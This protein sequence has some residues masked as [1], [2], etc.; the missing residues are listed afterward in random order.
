MTSIFFLG[1]TL[2]WTGFLVAAATWLC[3]G[4]VPARFA[5]NIWRGAAFLAVVPWGLALGA[6]FM[7]TAMETPIP[8]MPILADAGAA[9]ASSP[10]VQTAVETASHPVISAWLWV[11]ILCGWGVRLGLSALSQLRLQ[12]IKAD[13]TPATDISATVWAQRLGLS[14]APTVSTMEHGSPFLAG[15][16]NRTI[17]L[18]ASVAKT[19]EANI[20]LAHECTH[21]A[22]G[23]LVSRP[24]ERLVADIFW[25]SPFSWVMRRQLDYWREAATDEQT[26][27]LTGDSVAYARALASTARKIRPEPSIGLPVAA[28]I[29]PRRETLKMRLT[30]LLGDRPR[31]PRRAAAALVFVAS[32]CLAPLAMA[33]AFNASASDVFT[34]P[35]ILSDNARVTT[36]FGK[37]IDPWTKEKS[38][39]SG[40][41]IG[42]EKYTLIHAPADAKVLMAKEKP[43]YGVTVD[44]MLKD[45]RKMRFSQM[46]KSLVQKG[47][48]L[49]A[50][51]AIGKVGTS[52]KAKKPHLHLEVYQ[53]GEHIDPESVEGLTLCKKEAA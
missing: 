35:V 17:H 3:H 15:I 20:I 28:F 16:R 39:H 23:D 25:F 47:D 4:Q 30:Q 43:G 24:L 29:L 31:K 48:L 9:L 50:G 32:L 40:V 34:H 38:W 22:R 7:P 37:Q 2:I 18:P 45:G 44:V 49:K 21:I 5:H 27:A 52:G 13:A 10:A 12:K 14:S 26:A 8:D 51:D 1:F 33:N 46:Y 42:A 36:A 11:V 6:S 53:D 41:D 19:D